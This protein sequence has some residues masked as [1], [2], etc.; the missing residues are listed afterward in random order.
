MTSLTHKKGECRLVWR[1]RENAA[2]TALHAGS[3]KTSAQ[4]AQR[5]FSGSAGARAHQ[6]AQP[7]G[8][9]LRPERWPPQLKA[10]GLAGL[11]A[12]TWVPRCHGWPGQTGG[13]QHRPHV[14]K[15]VIRASRLDERLHHHG[16]GC[17]RGQRSS[18]AHGVRALRHAPHRAPP[19]ASTQAF[20]PAT[21]RKPD[22]PSRA[23]PWAGQVGA[24]ARSWR[25]FT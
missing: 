23:R 5:R 8:R 14:K 20:V 15:K 18:P 9:V 2:R 25:R 21:T 10:A 11:I 4:Q 24:S 1:C 19:R 3:D 13:N 12:P 16:R 7:S 6:K 17:D 22:T